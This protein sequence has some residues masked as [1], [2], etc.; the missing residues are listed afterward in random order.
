MQR[1]G[2]TYDFFAGQIA[3]YSMNLQSRKN[4]L[5]SIYEY[6]DKSKILKANTAIQLK[7]YFKD[8]SDLY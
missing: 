1:I 5:E 3:K 2:G 8:L 4:V 7:E 6:I